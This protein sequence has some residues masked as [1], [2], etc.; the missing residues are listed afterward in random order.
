MPADAANPRPDGVLVDLARGGDRAALD[1]LLARHQDRI[2]RFSLKMCRDPRDAEDVAQDT[3]LAVAR[4]IRDF[5]GASSLTTWLF[6][7]TR[8]FCIKRHRHSKFAPSRL[9]SLDEVV[10]HDGDRTR[11]LGVPP[12]EAAIQSELSRAVDEAIDALDHDQREVL[13][14]RDVEGLTAPEVAEV[15]GLSVA[16]VKSRLHRARL[17]V[18]HRLAPLM[19]HAPA[20]SLRPAC[21]DVLNLLSQKLEGD[22][23]PEYCA[24]MEKHV[25]GCEPCHAECESLKRSLALCRASEGPVVPPAVRER[26]AAE[27]ARFQEQAGQP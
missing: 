6:A 9:E 10:A 15:M 24:E 23:S 2:Y 7:I 26:L 22:V 1:A 13:V 16:A 17:F 11:D 5:R 19:G 25:E 20:L 12:D 14:L 18:R 21:P 8:S 27:L 3:M 4:T